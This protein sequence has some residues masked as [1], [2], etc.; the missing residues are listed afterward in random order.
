MGILN[1]SGTEVVK[2]TYDAW[3]KVL[4]TTGSLASTLGTVQPFRYRGYVYDVDT[5]FYYLRS[6]YYNPVWS[7]F[8]NAD[9]LIKG[10]LFSY[11]ENNPSSK[12]DRYG[13]ES[14][15]DF[16]NYE[17]YG[18][19]EENKS[20]PEYGGSIY[21]ERVQIINYSGTYGYEV[22]YIGE[23]G[24]EFTGYIQKNAIFIDKT[25]SRKTLY[26]DYKKLKD[27]TLSMRA[28]RI[29]IEKTKILQTW[30]NRFYLTI[31]PRE[32]G[33]LTVDGVYDY[34]MHFAVTNVQKIMNEYPRKE[35]L[36][37]DGIAGKKTIEA[38]FLFLYEEA[39]E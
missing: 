2:Y 29:H 19:I 4:S 25:Y 10:N 13:K 21:G 23:S 37:E 8:V 36:E 12:C 6:R 28:E 11:C 24:K 31:A 5:G 22:R 32:N 16:L 14:T 20:L 9:S 34:T 39:A 27:S 18:Y 17:V 7:K 33:L 26:E 35:L 1:T 30:L 15:Y 3:G 38:L